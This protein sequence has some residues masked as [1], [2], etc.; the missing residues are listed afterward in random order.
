MATISKL[1]L[2][3]S[4]DGRPIEVAANSGSGTT[5]HTGPAVAADF[6][7]IWL[8]ACNNNTSVEVLTL[9]WGGTTDSDDFLRTAIHPNETVL[10]A[11]GWVIKGNAGTALIVKAIST[12]ANKVSIVGYVNRIDDA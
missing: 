3:G 11:P 6:D 4:T 5:I 9:Q 2:S 8:W 7:E 12:T 10:V 1:A